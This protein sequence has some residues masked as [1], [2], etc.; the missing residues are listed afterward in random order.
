M[1]GVL[2]S[3][4]FRHF[5]AEEFNVS[6]EDVTA[7][8]LGGH[9]DT[10]VPLVKYSTVAGIPI[11]DLIDMKWTTKARIDQIVQRTRDGG[12][13]IVGLLKTGS[14]YYAPASAG[15]QMA[16]SYLKDQKRVL[17]CAA[18]LTGQYGVKD[19]YVGVPVVIGAGGVE[20]IVEI[21]LEAEDKALFKKSIA[22]VEGLMDAAKKLAPDL[23]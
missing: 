3:G 11:P 7:F 23:A 6:V 8:V 10:M 19:T 14:A 5:L 20:R 15:I 2:D 9:G 16:E 4:R 18:H 17:P 12:A 1:A 21:K 22:A 13:E